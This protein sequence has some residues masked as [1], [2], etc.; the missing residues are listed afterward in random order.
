MPAKIAPQMAEFPEFIR[1]CCIFDPRLSKTPRLGLICSS[2]RDSED[3]DVSND[4]GQKTM[5]VGHHMYCLVNR[6]T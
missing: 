1:Y 6:N 4:G 5:N 2:K 3:L